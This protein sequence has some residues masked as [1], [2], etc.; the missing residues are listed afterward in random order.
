MKV[1]VEGSVCM[2]YEAFLEG[3]KMVTK[4][5]TEIQ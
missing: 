4:R 3:K 2:N 1:K 5:I